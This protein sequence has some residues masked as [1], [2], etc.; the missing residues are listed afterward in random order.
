[1]LYKLFW[2]LWSL[3]IKLI[4]RSY[5]LPS[6]IAPAVYLYG[7]KRIKFG[8][9]LRIFP[10][11]RIEVQST[12]I[13]TI[14]DNFSSGQRLHVTCGKEV[15]IGNNVTVAENVMITDIDHSYEIWGEHI[16]NQPELKSCTKIGDN[17]FLG[18]GAVI[19]AGT[20]LGDQVIVGANSVVKG[21]FASGSVIVGAPARVVK[22][23]NKQTNTWEKMS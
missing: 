14:G 3:R 1:M 11:S 17:C 13:L 4:N 18:Y 20:V 22:R 5:S 12:G 15:I 6:Y 16:L 7:I 8:R 19:M 21:K 23:Y 9:R 2:A 10:H